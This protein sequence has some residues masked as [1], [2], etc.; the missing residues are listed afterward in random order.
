MTT[1]TL[2]GK[3]AM[4]MTKIVLGIALL[5][6]AIGAVAQQTDLYSRIDPLEKAL[7]SGTASHDQQLDLA[8]LYIQAGRYY[9]A[10]K[11]TDQ[12]LAADANDADAKSV[13][14]QAA[15]GIR[16]VQDRKVSEA[17]ASAHRS[18]ATDQDR[19]ALANAYFE[20]GSYGAAADIYGHLPAASLDRDTRLHYARALAWS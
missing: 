18:G 12:L 5:L 1:R 15:R 4:R 10:T 8:R 2:D 11:I 7:N 20:A 6:C 13:R 16:D 3:A 17:E 19:Q 14:D 9:D